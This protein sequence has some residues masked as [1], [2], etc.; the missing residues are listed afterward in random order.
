MSENLKESAI[1]GK[2]VNDLIK[3]L[4]DLYEFVNNA[5]TYLYVNGVLLARCKNVQELRNV[6]VLVD[7]ERYEML[8]NE[9][10]DANYALNDLAYCTYIKYKDNTEVWAKVNYVMKKV[11]DAMALIKQ[12]AL[13]MNVD[14]EPTAEPK[15]LLTFFVEFS[16]KMILDFYIEG[17]KVCSEWSGEDRKEIQTKTNNIE[18]LLNKVKLFVCDCLDALKVNASYNGAE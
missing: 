4:N 8:Q 5:V 12:R 10:R 15:E 11:D 16:S 7:G 1:V 14:V 13:E 2:D 9:L 18:M 6:D 3:M 17:E